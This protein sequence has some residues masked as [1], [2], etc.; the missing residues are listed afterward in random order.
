M[1]AQQKQGPLP[2]PSYT[3]FLMMH[4]TSFSSP[5]PLLPLTEV[6][7]AVELSAMALPLLLLALSS[8]GSGRPATN[9]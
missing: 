2:R 5:E 9:I 7:V 1:A 4:H 3:Q 8:S 6:V